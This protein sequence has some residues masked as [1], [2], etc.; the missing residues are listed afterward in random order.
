PEVAPTPPAPE[1]SPAVVA[2]PAPEPVAAPAPAPAPVVEPVAQVVEPTSRRSERHARTTP[3]TTTARPAA[4]AP[5]AA[6]ARPATP[7]PT[8][9]PIPEGATPMDQARACLRNNSSNMTVGNQ[10]V[11]AVL[12]NRASSESE[13]GLLCVTYRTMGQTSNAV[14]CMR[15]Y[16]QS[17]P[18]GPRVPNFQQFIDNNSN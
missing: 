2:A 10:C 4:P 14:R 3:P 9:T 15:S 7:A 12:R 5:T 18:D 13:R 11:V 6:P 1:P 17:H 8:S 16:I